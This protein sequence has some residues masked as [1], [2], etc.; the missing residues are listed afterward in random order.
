MSRSEEKTIIEN[1]AEND[2][3]DDD[4]DDDAFWGLTKAKLRSQYYRDR[5]E[6]NE[7][8]ITEDARRKCRLCSPP[9]KIT[10]TRKSYNRH[11]RGAHD[12]KIICSG[13]WQGFASNY[14]ID[15]HNC[16]NKVARKDEFSESAVQIK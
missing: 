10:F 14:Y 7:K 15:R 2:N 9:T 13:C 4:D 11:K 8:G 16:T 5:H 3:D 1:F 12:R 6:R